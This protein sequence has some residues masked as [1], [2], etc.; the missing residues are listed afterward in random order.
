MSTSIQVVSQSVSRR[1]ARSPHGRRHRPEDGR[2]G[3]P[4]RPDR[5]RGRPTIPVT[6]EGLLRGDGVFEVIRVYDGGPFALDDHLDRLERSAT[7]LRLAGARR[8]RAGD[9]IA[10]AARRA[11]RQRVRRLPAHRAHARRPPPAPDRA[12]AAEPPER[13]GSAS[14]PTR[15]RACSTA[16]S[17]SR[18]R[19]TCSPRGCAQERGFDEALL[20]TP[21][22]RVL[23]APD[24]VALLGRRATAR[25]CTPPL[26]EHILAS[27][28]RACVMRGDR[29]GGAGLHRRTT[30]DAG[31]R[32]VPG[33]DDARGAAGRRD[34]GHRARRRRASARARRRRRCARG[35]RRSWRAAALASRARVGCIWC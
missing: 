33:V 13:A 21:H 5:A 17:R 10:G 30:L 7:N 3:L 28:T 16:S 8:G 32:G 4:R 6:D 1:L 18:T 11:R 9:E 26:D 19:R 14:S 24:L 35:S 25:S 20:V 22:G 23:E 12:A 34:R 2:A 29:G 27:I 31:R 15:P